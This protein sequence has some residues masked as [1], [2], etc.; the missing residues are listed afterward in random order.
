MN[1]S[2]WKSLLLNCLLALA[3]RAAGV[4]GVEHVVVIGCDGMGSLA[5]LETNAP[6][7]HRLMREGAYTCAPVGSCPPPAAPTGPR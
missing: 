1:P 7:M 4:P 5:F 6:T 3:G 2:F